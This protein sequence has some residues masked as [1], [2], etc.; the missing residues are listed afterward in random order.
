MVA[1]HRCEQRTQPAATS[2]L[3]KL[4]QQLSTSWSAT[5]T[6]ID[7]SAA[8]QR[9]L[10]GFSKC[11]AAAGVQATTITAFFSYAT[12]ASH[13][14]GSSTTARS[15]GQLYAG[16]I[17]PLEAVRDAA[18]VR[19]RAT[20]IADHAASISQLEA[21]WHSALVTLERSGIAWPAPSGAA[22]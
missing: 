22:G 8:V 15:T 10:P 20:F 11:L 2:H 4:G 14:S 5:L 21:S 13:G 18:R 16:C 17:A 9:K 6:R 3:S 7:S 12:H 19:A 1:A